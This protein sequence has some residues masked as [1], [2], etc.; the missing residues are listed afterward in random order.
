[1]L[2]EQEANEPVDGGASSA[3]SWGSEPLCTFDPETGFAMN[4]KALDEL[5]WYAYL[6]NPDDDE[7]GLEGLY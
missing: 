1:M 4:P 3:E 6:S 2:G 5:R 7:V